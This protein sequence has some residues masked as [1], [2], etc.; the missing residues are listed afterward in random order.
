[1]LDVSLSTPGAVNLATDPDS[2][3]V[4]AFLAAPSVRLTGPADGVLPL[5]MRERIAALRVALLDSGV[6]VYSA[7]QDQEW[8][9]RDQPP[10]PRLPSPFRAM[11]SA[12][13]VFAYIGSPLSAAVGIELG[14][15]TA[16][17]KPIVLMESVT[18][19]LPLADNPDWSPSAWR[20]TV[21][22]ALD[23]SD[24]VEAL[25]S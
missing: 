11:Q 23:W 18:A 2:Y 6:M 15:A 3:P 24:C 7:H 1:M 4:R 20:R 5:R 13:I 22:T 12:D 19:V 25:V 17:R 10:G 8:V 14:W 16:L 9:S 21:V